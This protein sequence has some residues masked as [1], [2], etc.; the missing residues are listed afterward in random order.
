[1]N[2]NRLNVITGWVVFL[3]ATIVY[4]LC[5][6]PTASFWDC[7]EFIATAHKL[8]V[9]HP[10]GAPLFMLLAR[11][12][13][14]FTEPESVAFMINMLS[15]LSSSFTIL[16]LFWTIT[17]LAK[18]LV[19]SGEELSAGAI[20]AVLG[21]GA[22]GGLAYTFSDSFWF[23][24]V[25]GEVYGL[26]SL[27]TAVVFWAILKW[28]TLESKGGELRWLVL[29]AYLMGL[30][31]GVHLLNLL[32][33]P[34]ICFVYYFKKYPTTRKGIIW[35]SI[36]S[37]ALLGLIQTGIII[38][39]I[40]I[41]S[42]FEK[43]FV[44]GM[45][46]PF[47]SGV[48]FYVL[49]LISLI[50]FG[51]IY[52]RRKGK[53]M[54]NTLILG[55][56][57][58]ILG[59]CSF[60]TVIIRSYANP[61][62]DENN[63]QDVF[64]LLA[65][66]NR[67]QYGNRP[68]ILGNYWNTPL[69]EEDPYSDGP[70]SYVKSFSVYESG[71]TEKRV[72]SYRNRFEAEQFITNNSD[73]KLNLVTEYVETGEKK[74]SEPNYKKDYFFPRM[75]SSQANHEREYKRWSNYQNYNDPR[76]R[77]KLTSNEEFIAEME[78][79]KSELEFVL[80]NYASELSPEEAREYESEYRTTVRALDK[81]YEKMTPSFAENMR[82][83][84][85]YQVGWMYLRYFMWNFAGRQNDVQGHGD[86]IDGNW[87]TGI[88]M[89]DEQRL[90]NRDSLPQAALENKGYNKF[91][92]LPLI[93]G[94][95]GL[96][97]QMLRNQKDFSVVMMLFLLTGLAIV[98]YLNQ[99]PYQPR[100]RDYAYSGS[101]YA[102]SIWIGLGVFALYYASKHLTL[103]GLGTLGGMLLGGSA[104]IFLVESVASDSHTF[105]YHL[106][107]ISIVVMSAVGLMYL[108]G[109]IIK[110]EFSKGIL[111]TLLCFPAIYVLA[112]QGWDD[113]SRARRRTGVDYAQNYLESLA[114]NAIIFTNGDNDTFPL[115]YAQE[116]EGIRTDVRIVNM[117]L[118]NT[119]WYIDQMKRAAYESAPVPFSLTEQQY[120]QGTR[121][122]VVLDRG[123]RQRPAGPIDIGAAMEACKDDSKVK[124]YG[125]GKKYHSFPSYMFTMKVDSAIVE[126]FRP[127][128]NPG[129]SLVDE[130][131]WSITDDSGKNPRQFITKNQV[132]LM[133]LLN[134]FGWE[135]PLYFATTTGSDIYMG[136]EPYFQLEGMA[137]RLVPILH[138]NNPNPNVV[139]GIAPEVM[140]ENVMNKFK[141]G[142]VDSEDLY[143]DE[144]NRRMTTNLRLH[145]GNLADEF[146]RQGKN[147]K[148]LE[149]LNKSFEVM[150]ERNVPFD[151]VVWP[152]AESYFEAGD[153]IKG[154][155]LTKRLIDLNSDQYEYYQSLDEERQIV[156][157][158][159]VTQ[160]LYINQRLIM[161][162]EKVLGPDHPEVKALQE[163][164]NVMLNELGIDPEELKR[165]LGPRRKAPKP[166]A[167]PTDTLKRDTL[168]GEF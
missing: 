160:Q 152:M 136:L 86:F 155:E 68:L 84:M 122:I 96:V 109:T 16:F 20:I 9:G 151:R 35:T 156:M 70:P 117:S 104:F 97:F 107:F 73:K 27:F 33:I 163:K 111:A 119:D 40:K 87:L 161:A 55:I 63:P 94:L 168:K 28:E 76:D 124:D 164:E 141:W 157:E 82:F 129:D 49:L 48:I 79:R 162:A 66:L 25:E 166:I 125:G 15:V 88:S 38:W 10:P 14:A 72:Q 17:H 153:S 150:P 12:S 34:A 77:E 50:T 13:A 133:D 165:S 24:A 116:V 118:L 126:T 100:E 85:S 78:T 3:I 65:Y 95:I 148:A 114:P 130:I 134:T 140:Y 58:A 32:A 83:F 54:L 91:F 127:F 92:M 93:L 74:G 158:E 105:G 90:G 147:E 120:R 137:Y 75:Y 99:Y 61:P 135:R 5:V 62:I 23:S 7:G 139:G 1:M 167:I 19:P 31:I 56:T 69:N 106:F 59:Y 45:G 138:P 103:K 21:S 89:L 52:S 131:N 146:I 8:Q 4:Y 64:S 41:A 144:N 108:L 6:E 30:S 46:L 102:F 110:G 113:H 98:V 67:E 121:D 145:F 132:M 53:V 149:I 81:Q 123:T 22:I 36:I 115:W 154:L 18:K 57:M 51:L 47:N 80:T 128:L 39:L 42:F 43:W 143:M 29:I 71:R 11:V 2:F 60:A 101:F 159:D 44:N 112:A 26:S 37:L 142:N